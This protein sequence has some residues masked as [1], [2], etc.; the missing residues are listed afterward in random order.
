[1]RGDTR[2][3]IRAL[4][5]AMNETLDALADLADDQLDAACSHPCGRGP[6]GNRSVWHLIANDID[7][8]K[9]HA[10]QILSL[11]HDLGVMQTQ[12]ER[13]VGEWIKERAALAGALIG[14][15]DE[16]LDRRATPD[17]WS[18]REVVEHTLFWERDS[19]TATLRDLAGGDPWRPDPTVQY[20]G[21]VPQRTPAAGGV[22]ND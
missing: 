13:L 4:Q 20:G 8:E 7:H 22:S 21:P 18:I 5:D 15:P 17:E 19:L 12:T 9:M 3:L 6:D 14:L 1:M 10:G 2:T 11:R 16:A